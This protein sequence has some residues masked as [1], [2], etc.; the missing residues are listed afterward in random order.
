MENKGEYAM[1]D[2]ISSIYGRPNTIKT[3]D[4][5]FKTHI[6][7]T[8][9]KEMAANFTQADLGEII[10]LWLTKGLSP[11]TYELM[12][13]TLKQYIKWASDN[14]NVLDITIAR[15]K[16][17]R[18]TQEPEIRFL[19]RE[20]ASKLLIKAK[21]YNDRV[22]LYCL[23]GLHAGLR[24]GE[25]LGLKWNDFDAINNRITVRRSYQDGPTKSGKNRQIPISDDLA[26]A[27]E[28]L[29]YM[30]KRL[31]DFVFDPMIWKPNIILS[32]LCTQANIPVISSHGL[33]H[34]FATLALEG[35]VSPRTVQSWLGHVNL[36]TTLNTYW[37]FVPGETKLTF[38]PSLNSDKNS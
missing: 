16:L 6:K 21:A 32:K 8:V 13:G 19:T 20:Q 15:K 1:T 25:I 12:L 18:I 37:N 27:L 2:F 35:L 3:Y 34:T 14:Q 24:K 10:Q 5:I 31:A 29:D 4:S 11:A 22:Y 23:L 9:S 17:L 36:G 30:Q 7:P 33:R 38:V 28:E 26:G